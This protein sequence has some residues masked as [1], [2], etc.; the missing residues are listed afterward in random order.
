MTE[1]DILNAEEAAQL[2]GCSTY[3]VRQHAKTGLIPGRKLGKE[4][5]FYKPDLLAWLREEKTAPKE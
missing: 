5:R 4:W 1:K 3:T 2:L